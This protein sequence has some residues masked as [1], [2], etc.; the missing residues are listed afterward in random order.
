MKWVNGIAWNGRNY[1][2]ITTDKYGMVKH[3]PV[4]ELSKLEYSLEETVNIRVNTDFATWKT[5]SSDDFYPISQFPSATSCGH[6][7]YEFEVSGNVY[8]VPAIVLVKALFHPLQGLAPYLFRPQSLESLVIPLNGVER[9]I[10]FWGS[11]QGR[12]RIKSSGP[13]A[14]LYWL[15]CFPS[16]RFAWDSVLVHAR[17][18]KLG[19][20]LPIGIANLHLG[21]FNLRGKIFVNRLK[22]ISIQTTETPYE[23]SPTQSSFM[24]F[25]YRKWEEVG[26]SVSP[27]KSYEIPFRGSELLL[28]D[29]EWAVLEPILSKGSNQ[30]HDLRD[31]VNCL[32][33][34]FRNGI[35]WRKLNTRT[36]NLPIIV[37][38]YQRMLK[39]GRWDLLLQKLEKL[40]G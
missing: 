36:L 18:G 24:Q 26:D 11:A 1:V 34:K 5:V 31:I 35:A 13:Y 38:H 37:W 28:S 39:D 9:G 4:S 20:C 21:Y 12:L 14:A 7:I 2:A 17:D 6:E 40:R 16:A 3:T 27:P 15:Y 22:V 8:Q 29:N 10:G 32:L 30:K 23:F 33:E 19:L 25:N